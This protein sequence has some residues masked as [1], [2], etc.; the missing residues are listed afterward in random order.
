[1]LG[2]ESKDASVVGLETNFGV[3]VT[4]SGVDGVA[5]ATA[6]LVVAGGDGRGSGA[7]WYCSKRFSKNLKLTRAIRNFF[8]ET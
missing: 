4:S 1:M 3:E 5:M 8:K 2:V 7:G 6:M